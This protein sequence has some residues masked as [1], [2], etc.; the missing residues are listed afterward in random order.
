LAIPVVSPKAISEQARGRQPPGDVE[1]PR[2]VYVS[3]VGAAERHR[4]H[5]L[6]AKPLSHRAGEHPFQPLE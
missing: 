3:L 5:P 2:R 4:D 1:H 6:A